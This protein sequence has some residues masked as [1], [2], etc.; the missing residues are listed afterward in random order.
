[1]RRGVVLDIGQPDMLQMVERSFDIAMFEIAALAFYLERHQDVLL[2]AGVSIR[3]MAFVK[4]A[5]YSFAS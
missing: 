3:M 5:E 4:T 1:M 2:V